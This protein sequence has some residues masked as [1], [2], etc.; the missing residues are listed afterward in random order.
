[1][2]G[3]VLVTGVS[4]FIAKH[5]VKRFLEAGYT[6]RGTVRNRQKANQV[7]AALSP[8]CD[9]SRLD[10]CDA[11]LMSDS[12]W[13]DAAR[14]CSAIVHVASPFPM[15]QPRNEAELLEPAVE[16]TIRVLA[17]AK[18]MG[19]GRFVH[20]SSIAAISG[21]SDRKRTHYTE[22]D[23]TD[24]TSPQT[25]VYSRSKT[26]AERAARDFI[27]NHAPKIHYT[28]INP[29]FV[30]GPALD[31]DIG[32]SL[33]AIRSIM[34]GKYPGLPRLC[35]ACVDARDVADAHLM[36]MQSDGPSGGRYPVV[37]GSAWFADLARH[38]RQELGSDAAKVPVRELPNLI[39]RLI[40]LGD[41][42][43]RSILPDLGHWFE[44]DAAKT[45]KL[46]GRELI[47]VKDAVV[48]T[49]RS[50]IDLGLVAGTR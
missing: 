17:A 8:L 19:V 38:I 44:I 40:A 14:G 42:A 16:G 41:P 45:R 36:A 2:P 6:V 1:M 31:S 46:L 5:C 15:G 32:T 13:S 9:I 10:F 27:Q 33:E 28:S 12:G 22:D 7:R 4:G 47:P 20:T 26:L 35:L 49:A 18:R 34:S 21:N 29:G 23:W 43:A 11:D 3:T 50:L 24:V 39:V 48:A 30:L 25:S 37:A